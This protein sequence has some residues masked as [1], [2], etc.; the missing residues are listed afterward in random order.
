ML[1]MQ[2]ERRRG[3]SLHEILLFH[4][5]KKDKKGVGFI[6]HVSMKEMNAS[7]QRNHPKAPRLI[8]QVQDK[9]NCP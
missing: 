2:M 1:S 3:K 5:T 9:E 8:T 6:L 7:G 4:G